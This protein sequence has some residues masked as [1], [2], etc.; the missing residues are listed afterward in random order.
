M[1]KN[2]KIYKQKPF[3]KEGPITNTSN[4]L[5]LATLIDEVQVDEN[6]SKCYHRRFQS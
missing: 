3:I 4:I 1:I 2:L 5:A 6:V